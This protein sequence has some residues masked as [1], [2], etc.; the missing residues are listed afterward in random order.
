M[1]LDAI[2]PTAPFSGII[3]FMSNVNIHPDDDCVLEEIDR[4][5]KE[6]FFR[7]N[8]RRRSFS[9]RIFSPSQRNCQN[10]ELTFLRVNTGNSE[11][12]SVIP[13]C[14]DWSAVRCAAIAMFR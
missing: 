14:T 5:L 12:H 3:G 8:L 11:Q 2:A 10:Y 9:C 6:D 13:H 4:F 1:D 7:L